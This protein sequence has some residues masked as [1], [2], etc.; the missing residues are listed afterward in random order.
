MSFNITPM[1]LRSFKSIGF[2]IP[3]LFSFSSFSQ[4]FEAHYK[5]FKQITNT[6]ENGIKKNLATL[7]FDGY[8]FQSKNR[9]IYYKKPLYLQNY[10]DGSIRTSDANGN[11]ML[12]EVVM[13][14]IQDIRYLNFDSLIIRSRF[15]ISG[16]GEFGGG[17]NVKRTLK[18]GNITWRYTGDTQEINGLK[19]QKAEFINA[20]GQLQWVVWF[21]PDINVLAGPDG[22]RDLPGLVVEG[23]NL[24]LNEKYILVSY[25]SNVDIKDEVF[26]PKE[27]DQPFR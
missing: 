23:E 6:A 19:C 9:F 18:K 7:E 1:N 20:N 10:P 15:D 21:C 17:L 5:I 3:C 14:T 8:L 24:I 11:E 16:S 22:M 25:K 4:T 13:D 26:W 27:F 12:N 2:I